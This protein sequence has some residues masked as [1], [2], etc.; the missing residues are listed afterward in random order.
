MH[1]T[2]ILWFSLI[3]VTAAALPAAEPSKNFHAFEDAAIRVALPPVRQIDD[4]SCGV[5]CLLSIFEFYGIDKY[6]YAALEKKL[7]SNEDD[8]T[9]FKR[10]VAV[11]RDEGLA[12]EAREEMHIEEL[13]AL[14]E[15]HKPVI[16][17][18]QAYEA[19]AKKIP[20][21][22]YDQNVNGHFVVAIGFDDDNLYF[23]DPSVPRRRAFLPKDEFA[24]RWHDDEGTKGHPN[25]IRH[26]GLVVY[27]ER[28]SGLRNF[29]FWIFDFGLQGPQCSGF[30]ACLMQEV[31]SCGRP[32]QLL[33]KPANHQPL[34]TSHE[35]PGS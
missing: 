13:L 31:P 11:A 6:D 32:A 10:I 15:D 29:G 27:R 34:A 22:Y 5:A 30:D 18:M 24:R 3:I 4:Y 35:P 26:L 2:P 33:H 19:D 20:Q 17:S 23:M 8:G 25:V 7:S 21:I 14:L 1:R 9:D 16:V 28:G 12:A